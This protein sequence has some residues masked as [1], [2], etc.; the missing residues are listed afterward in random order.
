[1][2]Y[3]SL[4]EEAFKAMENAYAPYSDFKVGACIKTKDGNY[5]HGANIEN[6]S[7]GLT[8]C[9]ERT[10]CFSAYS[11][12]YRKDDFE[13]MAIVAGSNKL[14]T[15][16]GACRQVLSELLCEDTPIVLSDG[17]DM[18]ITNIRELLPLAFGMEYLE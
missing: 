15:P 17:K 16:C 1:M 18:K 4:I 6:V 2:K 7:Y 10:A 5:F 14:I 11:N 12:G 3:Q 8:N 9:A 13:A